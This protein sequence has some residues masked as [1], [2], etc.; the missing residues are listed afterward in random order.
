MKNENFTKVVS[1][2]KEELI[3]F[4]KSSAYW[5]MKIHKL[6][7]LTSLHGLFTCAH[8]H[9]HHRIK[10][11]LQL[12]ICYTSVERIVSVLVATARWSVNSLFITT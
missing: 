2:D 5:F 12:I 6:K 7:T 3:K 1:W 8:G 10:Q 9:T 11:I 4:W